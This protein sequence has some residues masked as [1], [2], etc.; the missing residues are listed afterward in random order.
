L[1]KV[2]PIIA[3]TDSSLV[4]PSLTQNNAITDVYM[5]DASGNA[6]Q[7]RTSDLFLTVPILHRPQG[8]KVQFLAIVDNGAMINAIDTAAFQRIA[9]RLALLSPS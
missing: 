5:V 7:T 9:C 6:I 1:D 3:R 4:V 8:E 2:D